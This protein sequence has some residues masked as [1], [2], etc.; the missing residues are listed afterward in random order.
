MHRATSTSILD[1][2]RAAG[3]SRQLRPIGSREFQGESLH[4]ADVYNHFIPMDVVA[5]ARRGHAFDGMIN[6]SDLY[7]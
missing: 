7:L 6:V 5:D 4:A 2:L 1:I 3:R